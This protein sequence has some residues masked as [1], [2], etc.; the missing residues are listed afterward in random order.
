M[1]KAAESG[2][3]A[4]QDTFGQ[5]VVVTNAPTKPRWRIDGE[6]VLL[7]R[8]VGTSW[9][10]IASMLARPYFVHCVHV[11]RGTLC[12]T[13]RLVYPFADEAP[14]PDHAPPG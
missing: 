10:Q 2:L 5:S 6:H 9:R 13:D 11:G 8:A 7:L 3:A 1:S 4:Q 12:S 14:N